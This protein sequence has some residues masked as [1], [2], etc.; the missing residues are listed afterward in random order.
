MSHSTHLLCSLLTS[1]LLSQCSIHQTGEG[2]R[3]GEEKTG[4]E[5]KGRGGREGKG[6]KRE[7]GGQYHNGYK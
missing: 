6:R 7:R 2:E 1:L 4:E 5:G 3:E